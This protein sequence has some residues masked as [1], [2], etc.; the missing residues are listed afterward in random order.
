[1]KFFKNLSVR[2]K[3]AV[4]FAAVFL[5]VVVFIL[6]YFPTKQRHLALNSLKVKGTSIANMLASTIAPAIEFEDTS[7]VIESFRGL[8]SDR[9]VDFIAVFDRQGHLFAAYNFFGRQIGAPSKEGVKISDNDMIITIPIRANGEEEVGKLVLGLSLDRINAEIRTYRGVVIILGIVILIL[10]ALAG[11]F[12]GRTITRPLESLAKISREISRRTGDL[13]V[14]VPVESQDEVGELATSFNNMIAGLREIIVKVLATANEV[15]EMVKQLSASSE[16]INATLQEVS[17]TVQEISA[18]SARTAQQVGETSRVV[19]EMT[20]SIVAL[21]RDAHTAV[22]K[23]NKIAETVNETMEVINELAQHSNEIKQFVKIISDIANQTNLLALNA[24]IEAARAGEAG[25]GFTVVAEEVKKLAE[26]SAAAAEQIGKIIN[27][28]IDKINNAVQ[29]MHQ[30]AEKVM[31]G[32]E[33]ISEV[34]DKIQEVMEKGAKEVE[35]R[36]SEIATM[37]ENAASAT[38]ET[39]AATEEIASS[40]EQMTHLMQLLMTREDELRKLVESFRV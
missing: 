23:M 22:E 28:I 16:D 31:E 3:I 2:V 20:S 5:V 6:I 14:K 21:T 25:R 10:G 4:S 11:I 30:S 15:S 35:E 13:T 8:T 7:S 32:R 37:T 17:A 29:N 12:V 34:S 27:D 9:D 19:E 40:M 33:I 39:S 38:E 18:G 1:M 36:V 24:S 26:D